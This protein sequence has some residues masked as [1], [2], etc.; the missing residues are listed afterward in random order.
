MVGS[1]E[2]AGRVAGSADGIGGVAEALGPA[3]G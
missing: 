2:P 1:V 3:A